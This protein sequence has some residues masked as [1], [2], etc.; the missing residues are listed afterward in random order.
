MIIG[1]N[2]CQLRQFESNEKCLTWDCVDWSDNEGD[3]QFNN[4]HEGRYTKFNVRFKDL[5]DK[6]KFKEGFEK[7]Y[8]ENSKI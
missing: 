3:S 1:E 8:W 4:K 7:A 2:L 5:V 6:T